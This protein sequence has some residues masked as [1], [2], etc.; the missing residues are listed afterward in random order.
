MNTETIILKAETIEQTLNYLQTVIAKVD[1]IKTPLT[2][3][4]IV[5]DLYYNFNKFKGMAND[6]EGV[7]I[8]P[9]ITYQ[10]SG[11]LFAFFVSFIRHL[12]STKVTITRTLE[13]SF[14]EKSVTAVLDIVF[15]DFE[16][17][18]NQD[19][20]VLKRAFNNLTV[21]VNHL[22]SSTVY[23]L[24]I[25]S[26]SQ[27]VGNIVTMCLV[28]FKCMNFDHFKLLT[29]DHLKSSNNGFIVVERIIQETKC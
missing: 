28:I 15:K 25:T 17:Q 21:S 12:N 3:E 22:T 4:K 20:T 26:H 1:S 24:P 8:T 7:E 29:T 23:N 18:G 9:A 19:E 2:D 13:T 6:L 11:H 14:R 27:C 10:L 5:L 16:K